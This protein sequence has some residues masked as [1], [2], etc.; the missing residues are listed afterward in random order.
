MKHFSY[1]VGLLKSPPYSWAEYVPRINDPR[2]SWEEMAANMREDFGRAPAVVLFLQDYD[3]LLPSKF[4]RDPFFNTTQLFCWYDDTTRSPSPDMGAALAHASLLLPTYEYLRRRVRPADETPAVWMPHAALPHFALAFNTEPRRAVL[5]VG[6]VMGGY[7]AREAIKQRINR[8]DARFAQF[9]HPGWQPG[10][11]FAHVD[12]FARAMQ[13]HVACIFDG[14]GNNFAVSKVF[15]VPATGSLMM[16]TDDI[17]RPLAALGLLA[18]EHFV[19]FNLSTLDAAVDWVLAPSNARRVDAMRAAAQKV[20]HDRHLSEHRARAI[21]AAALA[22]ARVASGAAEG[23]DLA[24]LSPFPAFEAWPEALRSFPGDRRPW[25]R[26]RELAAVTT[27][28]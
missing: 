1:T 26:R 13:A 23:L 14:S 28:P 27:R 24:A 18:G 21:H 9:A 6:M 11:S 3:L 15:E 17:E 7:P 2:D 25:D 12:D 22:A 4:P 19:S 5:L 20:V 10:A 16:I 8:G